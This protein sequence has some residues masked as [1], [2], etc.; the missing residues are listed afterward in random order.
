[1]RMHFPDEDPIGKRIAYDRVPTPTS[2]W[3]TIVG[4]VGD[5]HQVSP[6]QAARPEIFESRSQDWGR[7]NWVVVRTTQPPLSV[8]PSIRAAL[9]EIDPLIPIAAVK[10]LADVKKESMAKEDSMLGLLTAFGAL[11]LLLAAVGVYAVAAQSARQRTR[12]IGI[13]IALG[14]K[15]GDILGLVLKRGLTAVA[16]GLAVGLG[17]TLLAART[18]QSL[19]YGVQASDPSTIGAVALLLLLVS[20]LAC[21]VPARWATRVDPVRSLKME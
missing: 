4:V 15:A 13:R 6:A 7:N 11:A 21:W 14:A 17:A 8:L 19:L 20:A 16:I 18:L 1:V 12:E 9:K 2:N 10:T 3:Y 5:Q